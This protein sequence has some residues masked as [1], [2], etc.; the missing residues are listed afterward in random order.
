[1]K[2]KTRRIFQIVLPLFIGLVIITALIYC[3]YLLSAGA[4]YFGNEAKDIAQRCSKQATESVQKE[5]SDSFAVVNKIASEAAAV[6][7]I[8]QMDTFGK[9]KVEEYGFISLQLLKEGV[10]EYRYGDAVGASSAAEV[11]ELISSDQFGVGVIYND[12]SLGMPCVAVYC[13]V[14]GSAETDGVLVYYAVSELFNG[15]GKLH[16]LTKYYF[17]SAIDGSIVKSKV[18]DGMKTDV[19]HN[20]FTYLYALTESKPEIDPIEQQTKSKVGGAFIIH[21]D[22][23][24][25]VATSTPISSL[26]GDCFVLQLFASDQLLH[27]E[28]L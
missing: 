12:P 16:E 17:F 10:P 14:Y 19:S 20:V 28:Y 9:S 8:E 5:I 11:Q 7:G 1:M 22:G 18:S 4:D 27:S 3:F 15:E 13:P 24:E 6:S 26:N 25:Y 23:E 2:E 21:I